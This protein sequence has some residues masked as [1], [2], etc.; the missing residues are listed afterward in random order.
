VALIIYSNVVSVSQT[1]F[2]VVFTL[3]SYWTIKQDSEVHVTYED[4]QKINMFACVNAKLQDVKEEL[5]AK[6]VSWTDEWN[7]VI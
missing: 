5:D 7:T 6:K 3:D 2:N 4:Q 1:Y